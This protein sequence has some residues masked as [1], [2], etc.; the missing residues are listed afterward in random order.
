MVAVEVEKG[1][2]RLRQCAESGRAQ[3]TRLQRFN[4]LEIR[5]PTPGNRMLRAKPACAH[6]GLRST[7]LARRYERST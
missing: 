3:R 6:S 1:L 5:H 2:E 4:A 7:P